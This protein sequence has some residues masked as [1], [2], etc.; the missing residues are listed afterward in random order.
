MLKTSLIFICL[1]S[2][3]WISAEDFEDRDPLQQLNRKVYE[4]NFE[5]LDPALIKP[6][7]TLYDRLT[8]RPVRIGINNFFSNLDEIPNA[9]N[10]LLQG[11]IGQAANDTGRFI[12]NSV[13]GLGGV[14]DIAT[15]AGMQPSQGEDFGQTLAVWGV[16]EGPYL[17]L[18]FLGP[19]TLRDAPSNVLDS[20]LDPFA[21]NDNYGMR[22]GIKAIDI[23]ALRAELLGID[24]VMSGDKY[25][26][27]RDVYL[28]NR[29]YVIADGAI[30]DD[31]DDLEDY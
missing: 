30:E 1:I 3:S 15:D 17:M 29:E 8:P 20:F 31:F 7:A 12:V 21:Y 9:V 11:K 4:L 5:I 28:Q 16:S 25:I 22:A 2:S 24:D 10:S 27:V 14:F 23:V 6:I 18:P 19:S 26:F 13:F